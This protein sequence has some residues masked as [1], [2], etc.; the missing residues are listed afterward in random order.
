MSQMTPREIVQELPFKLR[1]T[2]VLFELEGMSSIEIAAALE[3]S[4]NT[5]RSRLRLA[6]ERFRAELSRRNARAGRTS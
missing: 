1:E 2:F 3:L 4:E 5:V 6:R